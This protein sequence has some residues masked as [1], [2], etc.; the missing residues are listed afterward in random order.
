MR[1]LIDMPLSP[2]LAVWLQGQGHEAVHALHVGLSTA[3]DTEIL[4]RARDEDRTIVTADLDFPQLLALSG[5]ER[6][7]VV[8]FR[9]GSYS[10]ADVRELMSKIL[11]LL[12][13]EQIQSAITVVD[14]HRIR[15]HQLP[16]SRS[17]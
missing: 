10:E 4:D 8:L 16:V 5:A 6:P 1:W 9:G 13:E 12:T 2:A 14:R 17:G 3:T 11:E 15:R 7:G